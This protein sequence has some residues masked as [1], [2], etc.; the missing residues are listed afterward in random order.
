MIPLQATCAG[1]PSIQYPLL[2]KVKVKPV[3]LLCYLK[4]FQTCLEV[5]PVPPRKPHYVSN[6]PLVTSWCVNGVISIDAHTK[7]CVLCLPQFF[8]MTTALDILT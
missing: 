5:N 7:F 1:Q 8:E 4:P 6:R 2:M 3:S